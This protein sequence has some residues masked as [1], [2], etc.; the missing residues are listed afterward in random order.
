M[1]AAQPHNGGAGLGD[2]SSCD[3]TGLHQL[4][5]VIIYW[6]S[7]IDFGITFLPP[8][9]YCITAIDVEQLLE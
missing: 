2:F 1:M 6:I 7:Y 8:G 9:I 3:E 4:V 5:P